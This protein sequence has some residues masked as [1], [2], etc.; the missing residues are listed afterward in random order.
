MNCFV[1]N[2]KKIKPPE[3]A[4]KYKKCLIRI[5]SRTGKSGLSCNR[6]STHT[7]YMENY[8][9]KDERYRGYAL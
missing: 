7:Q 6:W 3:D 8:V 5:F 1:G 9:V 4:K 2:M